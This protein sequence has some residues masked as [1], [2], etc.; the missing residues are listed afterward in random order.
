MHFASPV[1]W[2]RTGVATGDPTLLGQLYAPFY[3]DLADTSV[4]AD[5]WGPASRDAARETV[6][7]LASPLIEGGVDPHSGGITPWASTIGTVPASATQDNSRFSHSSVASYLKFVT[8]ASDSSVCSPTSVIL[9]TDGYPYPSS[10]GGATLY[11]RLA[12]LRKDLAAKVYVVGMFL[13]NAGQ[14]NHM[15]CAGAGACDSASCS[16]PCLDT[17]TDEWDTCANPD[18]PTHECAYLVESAEELAATLTAIVK[19]SVEN[20]SR[21]GSPGDHQRVRRQHGGRDGRR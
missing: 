15:A 16:T 20:R 12:A 8:T 7:A 21:D 10:E 9:L 6:E 2:V 4:P 3:M 5:K 17:P 11:S 1:Q 13:A 19:E 14:L 18:D